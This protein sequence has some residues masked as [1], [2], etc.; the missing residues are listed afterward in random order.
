MRKAAVLL[1]FG[2]A[3][4]AYAQTTARATGPDGLEA[5]TLDRHTP[6]FRKNTVP[7]GI[8]IARNGKIIRTIGESEGRPYFWNLMFLPDGK[9]IAYETGPFHW[10][11]TCVLMDIQSGKHLEEHDCFTNESIAAAPDW[12]KQLDSHPQIPPTA[13]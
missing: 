2:L 10:S 1:F 12:V 3:P 8:A 7:L 6:E 5:W 11:M 9:R 4:S 13:K